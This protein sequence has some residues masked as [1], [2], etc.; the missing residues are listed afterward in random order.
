ME[1]QE[2]S[3]VDD[4]MKYMESVGK[5]IHSHKFSS[6]IEYLDKMAECEKNIKA[7]H[8]KLESV[9]DDALKNESI[10]GNQLLELISADEEAVRKII[11]PFKNARLAEFFTSHPNYQNYDGNSELTKIVRVTLTDDEANIIKNGFV[12]K[13]Y[14]DTLYEYKHLVYGFRQD[15]M[16]IM[17]HQGVMANVLED[18]TV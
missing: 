1:N 10:N 13:S 16:S 2:F 15:V 11:R 4:F 9:I 6:A 7:H 18:I 8:S 17:R 12:Q 14:F 3:N 5:V